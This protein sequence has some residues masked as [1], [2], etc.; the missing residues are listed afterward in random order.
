MVERSLSMREV[1][2][3]MPLSSNGQ[4]SCFNASLLLFWNGCIQPPARTFRSM[5]SPAVQDGGDSIV[6]STSRCGRDN[7]GS[8]PS[9]RTLSSVY[10]WTP[11][12]SSQRK[13]PV[14][15][16]VP[17]SFSSMHATARRTSASYTHKLASHL[18]P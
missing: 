5:P 2:G 3:S 17:S 8:I 18:H 13:S 9:P 15:S 12:S 1:K 14:P 4:L 11:N 6:V 16:Q 10:W 7:L